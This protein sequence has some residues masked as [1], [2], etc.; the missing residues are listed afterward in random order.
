VNIYLYQ[1]F[2]IWWKLR[3]ERTQAG[4]GFVGDEMGLGKVYITLIIIKWKTNYYLDTPN[5][6]PSYHEYSA[7]R[8][9]E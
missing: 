9:M 1:G 7:C 6:S 3:Q 4:G 2:A 8:S 5:N